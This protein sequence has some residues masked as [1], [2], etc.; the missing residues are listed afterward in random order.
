L[1]DRLIAFDLST[2]KE[3]WKGE[4]PDGGTLSIGDKMVF[5]A[6]GARDGGTRHGGLLLA[7]ATDPEAG[8]EQPADGK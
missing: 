7:F 1:R 3:A 8:S 5:L 6:I 2:G 4:T